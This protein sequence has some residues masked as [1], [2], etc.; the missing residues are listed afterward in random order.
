MQWIALDHRVTEDLLGFLPLIF[1]D[2]D[3]APAREQVE[4]KYAHGGGWQPLPDWRV[5][6][7]TGLAKYPGDSAIKPVCATMIR[8]EKILLYPHSW[9]CII[10]PDGSY[11]MARID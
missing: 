8:D 5:D 4:A 11:E 6:V 1:D 10:Q 2:R 9:V 7:A 3:P